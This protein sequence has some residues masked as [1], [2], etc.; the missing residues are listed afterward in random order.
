[1][2]LVDRCD[3]DL[4]ELL[5]S[6]THWNN[7]I[8]SRNQL[9]G[10]LQENQEKLSVFD[11]WL[12]MRFKSSKPIVNLCLNRI[13]ELKP[14]SESLRQMLFDSDYQLVEAKLEVV[15]QFLAEKPPMH[16]VEDIMT[17]SS[18]KLARKSGGLFR[19]YLG[20]KR[21]LEIRKKLRS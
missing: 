13:R 6:S 21:W 7:T 14:P 9:I 3:K 10:W 2:Y 1:M 5:K 15:R 4:F 16:E 11:Y 19:E 12:V 20:Q 8:K 18:N 17:R